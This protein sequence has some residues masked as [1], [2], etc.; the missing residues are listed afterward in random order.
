MRQEY[1]WGPSLLALGWYGTSAAQSVSSTASG[2]NSSDTVSSPVVLE[3][4][5]VTAERRRTDAQ[6][7]PFA[8]TVLSGNDL[9]K[10]GVITVDSLQFATPG[11]TIDNVGQGIEFNIRGVG[12]GEHN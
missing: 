1:W 7:T 3:Q 12:K 11:A 9:T 6:R 4:V 5:V 8:A 10:M 2:G